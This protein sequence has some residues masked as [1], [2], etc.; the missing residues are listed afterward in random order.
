MSDEN[1]KKDQ[2]IKP[3]L[4]EGHK[5]KSRRDFMAQG[6]LGTMAFTLAPNMSAFAADCVAP[7]FIGKTPVIIIDLAGGGNIAGS[8]VIVGGQGGQEDFLQTYASLGLPPNF[9]PSLPGMTN[10]EMGLVFH[11]DS[12]ILRGIQT[13]ASVGT[14]NNTEGAI[15]CT[16]SDDDTGNNQVNPMYWLNKAGAKGQL[17]QLAGTNSTVSGGNGMSPAESVN[18]SIAPVRLQSSQ[19][20]VNLVGL[21]TRLGTYTQPK[22]DNILSTMARLSENKINN[23]P[24]RS[25]PDAIKALVGCSFF[26]T[27]TQVA[28]FSPAVVNPDNDAALTTIFNKITN[29]GIRNR[30]APISKLVVEGLIGSGTIVLGGYDYHTNT[31]QEGEVKDFELGQVIGAIM[32]LAA[33]KQKDVV[34]IVYTDGGVSANGIVDTTAGG[35]GKFGWAGDSGQRS[36]TLM[37][38]YKKDGSPTLRTNNKRQIGYFK[39]SGSVENSALLTSN[40]VVNLSKALVANYL[41]LHGEEGKLADVVSE[42]PFRLS[43][44]NYLVF[45]KL[46]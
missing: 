10:N 2:S 16:T 29:A 37:M 34:V 22:V 17:N 7:T 1:D 4:L 13:I 36:S 30:V 23:I 18:P 31:R 28:N 21:G 8:N 11:S 46:R 41:A 39:A 27:Q 5:P 3:L 14:R 24:R 15:F 33:V 43:L 44:E 20:A 19:D 45:D 12:G 38:V 42:D 26:Q 40:S 25:L 6:F 35:R 9:H 32:E